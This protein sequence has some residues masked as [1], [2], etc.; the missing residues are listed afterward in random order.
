MMSVDEIRSNTGINGGT[1]LE[2]GLENMKKNTH[3]Y[4]L[5]PV[6]SADIEKKKKTVVLDLDETLIH[7]IK[8]EKGIPGRYD[9]SILDIHYENVTRKRYLLTSWLAVDEIVVF[10]TA[11]KEYVNAVVDKLL[12]ELPAM[13]G[14]DN[15]M[16][17]IPPS[18]RL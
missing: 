18:H 11:S 15:N 4:I 16:N 5:S 6:A 3:N 10:S 8:L 17:I 1:T 13:E 12:Q 14:I 2:E 7:S 9:D